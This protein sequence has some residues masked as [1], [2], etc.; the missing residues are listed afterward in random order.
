MNRSPG[1]SIG[2]FHLYL[3][4]VKRIV[5]TVTNDLAFD[6]RM[7]RICSA[8]SDAGY[9]ILLVGRRLSSSPPLPDKKYGQKRLYCFFK[10]GKLFYAEYN[11]RLFFYLLFTKA[12]CICAIDLDTILP[13]YFASK[14]KG[15]KKVYDAHEYFSQLDEV[16]SRPGIYRFWHWV[17]RK[18]IPRFQN[19]YT[20]CQGIADEFQKNYKVT[21]SVIRNVPILE[22]ITASS[23]KQSV[24]LY[25]GA[26]N[27][28][29]GLDKLLMAVKNIDLPLWICGDGNYMKELMLLVQSNNL[30]KKVVFFGMLSPSELKAKTTSVM[31]AINPFEKR[32]LNQ[33]L[34]LANKF[35]DYIHA[36]VPQITMNYPEYRRINNEYKIAVLIDDLEPATISNAVNHL[37]KEPGLY[38]TLKQNC[39]LAKKELNWQKEK[40]KLIQFYHQIFK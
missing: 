19:G 23:K 37:L 27:K 12:D 18:M 20:V 21:Y 35:F 38:Q 14:I 2:A 32:G 15:C 8:L 5:F 6:Q 25:Q 22:D 10:K 7:Q 31:I 34:S 3:V 29:R 30:D 9:T 13:C 39:L 24:L 4:K 17:E 11:L 33:Y 16:I 40:D 1:Y 26:V 36:G 28:G